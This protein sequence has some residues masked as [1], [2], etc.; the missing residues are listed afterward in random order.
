M[1][2]MMM[3]VMMIME[4]TKHWLEDQDLLGSYGKNRGPRSKPVATRVSAAHSL[5]A[6]CAVT[7]PYHDTNVKMCGRVPAQTDLPPFN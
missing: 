7:F 4:D 6:T 2:M 1:M 5:G 3:M